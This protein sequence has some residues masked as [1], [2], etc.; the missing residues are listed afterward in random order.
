MELTR[1]F[2]ARRTTRRGHP[3]R[4]RVGSGIECSRAGVTRPVW[5]TGRRARR[6]IPSSANGGRGGCGR[7]R[8][9]G[10]AGDRAMY[11]ALD[12]RPLLSA[13]S[14]PTLV[15]YRAEDRLVRAALSRTVA[16]RD[17]GRARGGACG[18]GPSL[19]RGRSGRDDRRDRGVRHG[20]SRRPR[21]TTGCS[22]RSSSPTSSARPTAQPSS[23]TVVGASCS[24]ST[25]G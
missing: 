15:L 22:R 16:R 13:V 9:R 1:G 20:T 18:R 7:G 11:E 2:R 5:T 23:G 8:V 24:A 25:V 10:H 12:V 3:S 21:F 6:T 17:P 4:S 14:M 19:H